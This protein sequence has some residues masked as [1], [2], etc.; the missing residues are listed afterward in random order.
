MSPLLGS[1][2]RYSIK[3]Y[4][5]LSRAQLYLEIEHFQT[6]ADLVTVELERATDLYTQESA[7]REQ[8]QRKMREAE[9]LLTDRQQ[10]VSCH[11]AVALGL[12]AAHFSHT[13]FESI[14]TRKL[15]AL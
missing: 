8:T 13:F 1:P 6:R 15:G 9:H 7:A 2:G 4:Q 11:C 14:V 5:D 3:Q 10:Q 12:L